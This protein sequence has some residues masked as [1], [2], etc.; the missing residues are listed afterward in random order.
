MEMEEAEA[1]VRVAEAV[2]AAEVVTTSSRYR[3]VRCAVQLQN[4]LVPGELE[5]LVTTPPGCRHPSS[6]YPSYPTPTP[7]PTPSGR[8]TPMKNTHAARRTP[9][10]APRT[11]HPAPRTPQPHTGPGDRRAQLGTARRGVGIATRPGVCDPRAAAPAVAASGGVLPLGFTRV[12]RGTRVG[13]SKTI[14]A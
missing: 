6:V 9:H 8:S 10:A 4:P 11:P 2:A 3:E 1:T 7:T 12:A 5:P 13:T 14:A